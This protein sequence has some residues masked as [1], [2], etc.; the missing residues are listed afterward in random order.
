[1]LEFEDVAKE[2]AFGKI[3]KTTDGGQSWTDINYG[4]GEGAKQ[5]FKTSSKIKFINENIGF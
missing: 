5:V 1:M 4:I 2:T 3:S